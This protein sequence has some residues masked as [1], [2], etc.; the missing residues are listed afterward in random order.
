MNNKTSLVQI[1]IISPD[2]KTFSTKFYIKSE[3]P[4]GVINNIPLGMDRKFEIF[5]YAD[6]HLTHYGQTIS[7][8]IPG[9]FYTKEIVLNPINPT[10]PPIMA[11]IFELDSKNNYALKFDGENDYLHFQEP[12]ISWNTFTVEAWVKLNGEG[13]GYHHQ[14]PIFIQRGYYAGIDNVATI[15]LFAEGTYHQ[16]AFAI[17]STVG[18]VQQISGPQP[19]YGVWH[20][21]AGVVD[22]NT[23]YLYMDGNL[24]GTMPNY[25]IGGF[26]EEI[27]YIELGRHSYNGIDVGFLNG[28]IDEVR[29]WNRPLSQNEIQNQMNIPL[30]GSENGLVAYWK[31]DE[32]EGQMINDKTNHGFIGV[33]GQEKEVDVHDPQWITGI[34]PKY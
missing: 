27:A 12:I 14:N 11:E 21:Y 33:L 31:M 24:I 13:G 2:L 22:T 10:D 19:G 34:L 5:I 7:N 29:I 20:H 3:N 6:N 23:V 32:G 18:H 30:T 28:E 1:K 15:A 9:H 4:K 17:R 16:V 8:I 26:D 25:Q